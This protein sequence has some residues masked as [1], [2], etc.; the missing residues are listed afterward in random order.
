MDNIYA[1][2]QTREEFEE[3]RKRV[4]LWLCCM[5]APD[6]AREHIGREEKE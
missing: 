5:F 3:V 4:N 6:V 1:D 2:C